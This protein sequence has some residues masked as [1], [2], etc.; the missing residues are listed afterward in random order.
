MD[1]L[2]NINMFNEHSCLTYENKNIYIFGDI[3]AYLN[4]AVDGEL[5]Y[6]TKNILLN[7]PNNTLYEDYL[8][9]IFH[10][11]IGKFAVLIVD[12]DCES[13]KLFNSYSSPGLYI[14]EEEGCINITSNEKT[15]FKKFENKNGLTPSLI[16]DYLTGNH[17]ELYLGSGTICR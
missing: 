2:I 4:D 16:E 8:K 10:G 15:V 1:I 17:A 12:N 3:I 5:S 11:F 14:F 7:C 6:D 9:N 13:Y